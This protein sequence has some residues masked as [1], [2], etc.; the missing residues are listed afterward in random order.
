MAGLKD[1][2]TLV[3]VVPPTVAV[4]VWLCDGSRETED[5]VNVIDTGAF[6]VRLSCL[7]L[8]A[9][10]SVALTVNVK[11][12]VPMGAPLITPVADAKLRPAGSAPLV[13]AHVAAVALFAVRVCEYVTPCDA[14]GNGDVV[15]IETAAAQTAIVAN[16]GPQIITFMD[17]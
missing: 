12:P 16:A 2:V 10:S 13:T 4:N 6:T 7:E 5:G 8:D 15:A 11:T 1:H 17:L 3:L 14:A 9:P